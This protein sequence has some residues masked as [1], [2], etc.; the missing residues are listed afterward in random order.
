MTSDPERLGWLTVMT[1]HWCNKMLPAATGGR[2]LTSSE[3]DSPPDPQAGQL[4]ALFQEKISSRAT[5]DSTPGLMGPMDQA[6]FQGSL[7]WINPDFL[8]N[9]R[10]DSN[11]S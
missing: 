9:P 11:D 8:I 3:W 5:Y 10:S 7:A 6:L 1:D 2:I 4:T